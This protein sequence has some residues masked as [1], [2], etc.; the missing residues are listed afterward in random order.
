MT[1]TTIRRWGALVALAFLALLTVST[2]DAPASE[3]T[4]CH[5]LS[6]ASAVNCPAEV[7]AP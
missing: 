6:P 4:A 5:G 1:T 3:P 2:S 7:F